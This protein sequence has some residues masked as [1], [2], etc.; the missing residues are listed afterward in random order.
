MP[1]PPIPSD[2]TA[3]A[4][5]V[6]H[7]A[8]LGSTNDRARELL[9]EP[10]GAGTLVVADEQLEGRGRR[11]RSW[12]SPPARNL[13]LSL[14]LRPQLAAHD[15][16]QLGFAAALAVCE[17]CREVA[18]LGVKWPN[19]LVAGDGAK[20]AGLLVETSVDG[21]RILDAI[22]GI[23]VNVNWLRSE[24]PVELRDRATS[25]AE[26]SGSP[27]D[28]DGLLERLAAALDAELAALVAGRSP[29]ER[30]R[31]ASVLD[32]RWVE[33]EGG[34]RVIGGHVTGIGDDGTLRL[35]T[36]DGD[37]AIGHGEVVR[38]R[39]AEVAAR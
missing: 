26:L 6:E 8:R 11:G 2:P 39:A 13:Y 37:R 29:L 36:A 9:R 18:A 3:P 1:D 24:M 33:V 23:G 7:H 21:E 34:G 35:A 17:A 19:D 28:R 20:V 30:Y 4:R 12:V 16:W 15:A 22:V 32:G 10:H 38:V 25:L 31:A 14:P 5:R 27:I